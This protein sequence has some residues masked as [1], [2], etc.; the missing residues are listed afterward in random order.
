MKKNTFKT[1]LFA[2]GILALGLTACKK[3]DINPGKKGKPT[4]ETPAEKAPVYSE[5]IVSHDGF[6]INGDIISGYYQ[7]WG[8]FPNTYS[9]GINSIA[10]TTN[11]TLKTCAA[12]TG[13]VVYA[14][15]NSSGIQHLG[16]SYGYF[17]ILDAL[18]NPFT[19]AI[20]EIEIHPQTGIVYALVTESNSKRIYA[21]DPSTG[22]STAMTVN[23]GPGTT[24]YGGTRVNGYKGGSICFIP[25]GIGGFEL[26]F[27][28]ESDVYSAF[29]VYCW[30]YSLSG[31]DLTGLPAKTQNYASIPG[32]FGSG[33]N[34]TYGNGQVYFARHGSSNAL[35]TLSLT[36]TGSLSASATGLSTSNDNDFGYWKAF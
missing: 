13:I 12:K 22:F 19:P 30:H 7:F 24:L 2:T 31:T 33:I 17:P 36:G 27:S 4:A 26:L 35:Y 21:I 15:R 5:G 11:T 16:G 32:T 18:G 10:A 29:G 14:F 28:H 6:D 20:E 23:G 1:A 8:P 9:S 34:T 25:D 3:E